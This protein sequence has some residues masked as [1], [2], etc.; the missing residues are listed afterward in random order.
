MHWSPGERLK[1]VGP[2]TVG[3]IHAAR[4][5]VPLLIAA[6][7]IWCKERSKLSIWTQ[8]NIFNSTGNSLEAS[9]VSRALVLCTVSIRHCSASNWSSWRMWQPFKQSQD[10]ASAT[11]YQNDNGTC[12]SSKASITGCLCWAGDPGAKPTLITAWAHLRGIRQFPI[13]GSRWPQ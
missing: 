13:R 4:N 11:Y 5:L 10:V 7:A 8:T 6:A 9:A 1:G 3:R 12:K 2:V